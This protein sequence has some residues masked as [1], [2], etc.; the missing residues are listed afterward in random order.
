MRIFWKS[1]Q[2][3]FRVGA[4]PPNPHQAP[5]AEGSAPRP[6]RCYFRLLITLE[7]KSKITAVNVFL[8]FLHSLLHLFFTS[9]SVV[10]ADRGRKK[11]SCPRAQGIL[12]TPL[13]LWGCFR[14]FVVLV[15]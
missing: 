15:G 11:I 5:A 9:N 8:L 4:P 14:T 6:P 12:A 10:F 13:P 3:R 1:C 2:N 7:K